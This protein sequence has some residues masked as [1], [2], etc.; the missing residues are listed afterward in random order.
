MA[1]RITDE[2][3]RADMTEAGI[4]AAFDEHFAEQY[5]GAQLTPG[6]FRADWLPEPQPGIHDFG[7]SEGLEP[8]RAAG[9]RHVLTLESETGEAGPRG[10]DAERRLGYEGIA[11]HSLTRDPY[12][13]TWAGKGFTRPEAEHEPEAEAG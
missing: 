1:D 10:Y 7:P 4:Q 2:E 3:M 9:E 6:G 12:R 8:E 13:A 5:K 11:E